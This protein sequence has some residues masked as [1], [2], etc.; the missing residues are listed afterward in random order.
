MMELT[1]WEYSTDGLSR[2]LVMNDRLSE[3]DLPDAPLGEVLTGAG[4]GNSPTF[5]IPTG[6]GSSGEI[7]GGSASSTYQ[8]DQI[9]DCGD[10]NG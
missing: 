2:S 3:N 1:H 5:E 7:D 6:G 4:E 10:A 8:T 9:I